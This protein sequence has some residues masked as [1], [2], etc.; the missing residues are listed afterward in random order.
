MQCKAARKC[1][2]RCA[3]CPEPVLL[4]EAE[5]VIAAWLSVQTQ[6]RTG[7]AGPTGLDYAGVEAALRMRGEP[8]MAETFAG[9]QACERAALEAARDRQ[10]REQV[11]T[12]MT[13]GVSG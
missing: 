12:M 5:P 4:P 2:T 11:A 8:D 7:M 10:Q 6:W 3:T 13:G 1:E 9:L